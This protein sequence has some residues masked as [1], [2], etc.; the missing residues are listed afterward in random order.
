MLE[1]V[2]LEQINETCIV[3]NDGQVT[4]GVTGGTAPYAYSWS[5]DGMLTDSIASGLSQ[6]NYTVEV[7][8]ANGC[9]DEDS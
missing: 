3:G 6:G 9:I 1:A 4:L 7:T 8:D 2:I 5:H